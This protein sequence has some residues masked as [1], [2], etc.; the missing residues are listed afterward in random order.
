MEFKVGKSKLAIMLA[1]ITKQATD[2]IV[3]A[4]NK[5]LSPGG[6]VSG[7]I[8]RAAGNKLWDE[9]KKLGGCI[10]GE[11]KITKGYNL[12]AKYVIHTVGPVYSNC[13]EDKI[14]LENSYRNSLEIARENNFKSISFP[15]ISTGNFGYPIN[16]ASEIAI[17]TIAGF[18]KENPNII[19]VQMVLFSKEDYEIYKKT[20]LKFF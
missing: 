12:Q 11:S 1:D 9:C 18:L 10:T 7:A 2:A 19:I 14:N 17:K 20:A 4:A 5:Y 16:E 13:P 8:H 6:G 3:N 15:S